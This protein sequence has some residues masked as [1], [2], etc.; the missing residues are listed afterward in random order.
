MIW[1]KKLGGYGLA[2]DDGDVVLELRSE[3]HHVVA[4][5]GVGGMG[6]VFP[7]REVAKCSQALG[8]R[9]ASIRSIVFQ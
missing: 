7:A 3:R 5:E 6:G 8:L 1:R 9:R 2:A 4:V